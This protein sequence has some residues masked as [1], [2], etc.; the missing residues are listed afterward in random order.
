MLTDFK[1]VEKLSSHFADS[2]QDEK[3]SSYFAV[4]GWAWLLIRY[5]IDPFSFMLVCHNLFLFM[6]IFL[7]WQIRNAF[8]EGAI[9][10]MF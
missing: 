5:L 6:P 1:Q 3:L 7:A 8:F 10:P 2:E 9:V 4:N